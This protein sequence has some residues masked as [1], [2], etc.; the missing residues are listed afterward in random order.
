MKKVK[1][2]TSYFCVIT[3]ITLLFYGMSFNSFATVPSSQI[4]TKHQGSWGSYQYDYIFHQHYFEVNDPTGIPSSTVTDPNFFYTND[5]VTFG[6]VNGK[7]LLTLM[8]NQRNG[9]VFKG[10]TLTAFL[11]AYLNS[12][13]LPDSTNSMFIQGALYDSN[14]NFLGYCLDDISGCYFDDAHAGDG[15]DYDNTVPNNLRN[16]Y[17]YYYDDSPDFFTF[18]PTENNVILDNL[19]SA[20]FKPDFETNFGNLANT[21]SYIHYLTYSLTDSKY[22]LGN[23]AHYMQDS[24]IRVSGL[25][26]LYAVPYNSAFWTGFCQRYDLT[27]D[28][29]SLYFQDLIDK[30][31][32]Y[33]AGTGSTFFLSLLYYDTTSDTQI[34]NIILNDINNNTTTNTTLSND[35]FGV[36]NATTCRSLFN[37]PYTIY[38]DRNTYQSVNV[39]QTYEPNSF[40]TDS[41]NNY[42]S[43]NDESTHITKT[44]INNSTT[45]NNNIYTA[46]SNSYYDYV[47]NGVVNTENIT[48]NITNI[49][50]NYYPEQSDNPDNPENPD[51]PDNPDEPDTPILDRLLE[52]ILSF[53]EALGKVI[54]TIL[55]GLIEMFASVLDAIAT[56]SSDIVNLSDFFGAMLGW[57][58]EPIPQVL[59]L[60]VSVCI[61]CAVIKFIRG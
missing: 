7:Q 28:N 15:F 56:I 25:G 55:T 49:T 32:E 6:Y 4:V 47:D 8:L 10:T 39:N 33:T 46:G 29:N 23:T 43:T 54:G 44:D 22:T 18:Y 30:A 58:P 24:Y 40:I 48:N 21:Y 31:P 13:I 59:G 53:F 19:S 3:L 5:H 45:T 20:N 16:F 2:I 37:K 26:S 9:I 12:I 38:K 52:A 34:T 50:N 14:R 61:L 17:D 42:D 60:G 11:A 57:L 1:I 51:N 36:T 41:Y 27:T 35:A